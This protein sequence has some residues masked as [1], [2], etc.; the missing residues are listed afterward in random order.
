MNRVHG[1]ALMDAH[2]ASTSSHELDTLVARLLRRHGTAV[3]A[4]LYYGSCMRSNDPYA[5]IVDL[6][7]ITDSYSAVYASKFHAFV[8]WL[9]PPNVYYKE[10]PVGD[11]TL[12]VKYNVLSTAALRRGLSGQWIHSYLWG[13]FSQP[14]EVLWYRDENVRNALEAYFKLA[15]KTFL[16]HVLPKVAKSGAV[17]DLWVQGLQLSY[18]AELRSERPGRAQELVDHALDHYVAA[19]TAAASSLRYPL[20]ITGAGKTARYVATVPASSRLAGRL[21]WT[22]L[23]AQGKVLSVGRLLKALIT[24]EGGLDYV[25]WKLGRHSGQPIEI[26]DRV[27]RY[28]V[29]FVWG[30]LWKLYRRGIIR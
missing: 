6:Y 22:I 13:R 28:P 29:I 8:N 17:S 7:L 4:I 16:E 9:L 1:K 2:A 25:A 12:R 14:I 23:R 21:A 24:F 3:N 26:P 19:S 10:M 15:A 20:E 27:R 18:A 5:G 11:R 30:L